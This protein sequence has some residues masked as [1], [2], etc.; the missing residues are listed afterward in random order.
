MITIKNAVYGTFV[1]NVLG[2]SVTASAGEK[3]T[4]LNNFNESIKYINQAKKNSVTGNDNFCYITNTI[5]ETADIQFTDRAGA[6]TI[7]A[8]NTDVAYTSSC[9]N[10]TEHSISKSGA[11]LNERQILLLQATAVSNGNTFDSKYIL[12]STNST[13]ATETGKIVTSFGEDEPFDFDGTTL[14]VTRAIGDYFKMDSLTG[15]PAKAD[16]GC[17]TYGTK[18]TGGVFDIESGKEDTNATLLAIAVYGESHWYWKTDECAFLSGPADG[19][20]YTYGLTKSYS[21]D[22][23]YQYSLYVKLTYNALTSTPLS[24]DL[25]K[26]DNGYNPVASYNDLCE[27]FD[28][29]SPTEPENPEPENNGI[30]SIIAKFFSKLFTNAKEFLFDKIIYVVIDFIGDVFNK[31]F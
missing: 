13:D 29:T 24:S 6:N 18:V 9:L 17:I 26:D 27:E 16:K 7:E 25:L 28:Y 19:S 21:G 20:N 12:N 4:V 1:M 30:L 5:V 11:L 31:A 10:G 2:A 23:N 15:L 3:K 8:S 14:K 22:G